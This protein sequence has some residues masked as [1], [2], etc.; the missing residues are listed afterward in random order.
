MQHAACSSAA[1]EEACVKHQSPVHFMLFFLQQSS[2]GLSQLLQASAAAASPS[3]Q[4]GIPSS[5]RHTQ[6][7]QGQ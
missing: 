2:V 6:C 5:F 3:Q 1:A 7:L 4:L